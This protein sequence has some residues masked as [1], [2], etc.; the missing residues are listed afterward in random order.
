MKNRIF[1]I[2]ESSTPGD[3]ASQAVNIFLIFLIG[4][5]AVALVVGTVQSIY[6]SAPIL[7]EAFEAA[8]VV[9]FTVE[10]LLRLWACTQD[11]RYTSPVSG[12][13]PCRCHR[14]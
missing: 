3:R 2:L 1:E 5:N 8:S 10:Y 6:Q 13:L 7:F 11:P 14:R 9:V 4:L 12:R